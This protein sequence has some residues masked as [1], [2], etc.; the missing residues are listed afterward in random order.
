MEAENTPAAKNAGVSPSYNNTAT[1]GTNV[2]QQQQ[3]QQQ[4][5]ENSFAATIKSNKEQNALEALGRLDTEYQSMSSQQNVLLQM[6]E[7]LQAE[8][9][10]LVQA[11]AIANEEAAAPVAAAVNPSRNPRRLR[12]QQAVQRLE[13]ALTMAT[14]DSSSSSSSEGE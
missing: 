1:D 9:A 4:R 12:D 11:I 2:A 8:E 7:K 5:E 10:C 13:N 14:Q 6:L 3:Q